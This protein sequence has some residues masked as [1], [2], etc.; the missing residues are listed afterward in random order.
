MSGVIAGQGQSAVWIDACHTF[1]QQ[2][3]RH[4]R[5]GRNHEITGARRKTLVGIGVHEQPIAVS[6]G[7]RHAVAGDGDALAP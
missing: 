4:P 7:R 5:I 6:Q 1:D 2:P 3:I